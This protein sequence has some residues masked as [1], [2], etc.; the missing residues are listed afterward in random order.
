MGPSRRLQLGL[1]LTSEW[2]FDSKRALRALRRDAA[3]HDVVLEWIK[4]AYGS[5]LADRVRG[6]CAATG[7]LLRL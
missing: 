1:D 7:R 4:D 3:E 5:E 6:H 2:L